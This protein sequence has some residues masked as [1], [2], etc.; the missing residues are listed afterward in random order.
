VKPGPVPPDDALTVASRRPGWLGAL[1]VVLCAAMFGSLG[2]LSRFAYDDGMAPFAFV[3]WRAGVG[4][5]AIW[6]AILL[7]RRPTRIRRELRTLDSRGRRWLFV[8]IVLAGALNLAAFLSFANT[9]VALALLGFY[10]YP[11]MV[12]AG[13]VLLGR[14]RLDLARVAALVLALA[15]MV[16]VVLGGPAVDAAGSAGSLGIG[17][18]LA[19]A[20]FQTGFVLTSRGYGALAAEYAMGAILV[21]SAALSIVITLVADGPAAIAFPFSRPDLLALLVYVGIFAAAVPSVL[22]LTGIRWIGGV[23]TGILMLF[24]PVV[25]VALAAIFLAEGLQPLQIAGGATILLAA[26]LVQRSGGRNAAPTEPVAI[27]PAPGG[28]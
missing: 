9:T 8:A 5:L 20:L 11:A 23:R 3:A 6:L 18:A 22:F 16:A 17:L 24:E 2:T 4:A 15:G 19:A 13:S 10:T 27:V 25:G 14:E 28:P 7:V 1:I 26:L 12:A 21:G